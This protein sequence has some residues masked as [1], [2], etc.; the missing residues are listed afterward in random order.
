[1]KHFLSRLLLLPILF[2]GC[3]KYDA[4]NN[5]LIDPPGARIKTTIV[6]VVTDEAGFLLQGATIKLEGKITANSR[7]DGVFIL[8]NV[9]V[10]AARFYLKASLNNY[11]ESGSGG[12]PVKGGVT[13]VQIK[14]VSMGNPEIVSSTDASTID[15]NGAKLSFPA[16]A[17]VSE[18]G[19][20]H[21]GLVKVYA[22]SLNPSIAN[23]SDLVPGGDLYSMMP[24]SSASTL[25]SYGMVGVEL[26]DENNNEL[27]LA[28]GK[29][30]EI[31][32]PIASSQ[33]STAPNEI[34]LLW[35]DPSTGIWKLEGEAK[36]VGNEYVGKVKHFSWWNCDI[37]RFNCR[38]RGR[39]VDCD[40]KPLA[41]VTVVVNHQYSRITDANGY[42]DGMVPRI[43]LTFEVK[44]F[45][46][47]EN[48][49]SALI[50]SSP[51]DGL[52]LLPDIKVGNCPAYVKGSISFCGNNKDFYVIALWGQ[53]MKEGWVPTMVEGSS[54][55]LSV[56]VGKPVT[57]RISSGNFTKDTLIAALLN[58]QTL[59]L[60]QIAGC[61][62]VP[63]VKTASI[64][65]ASETSA[66]SGGE[67]V[68]N[69]GDII[70]ARGVVW[71]T[72]PNP[73]VNLNTKTSDGTGLGVYT[74][75]IAGL[76]KNTKYYLRAY[77][78]NS[79]GTGY[80]NE[81]LFIAEKLDTNIFNSSISYGSIADID[82]NVYKTVQIGTQTWMAE[83]LRVT[84]YRNG[85][86]IQQVSDSVQWNNIFKSS[87]SSKQAAWCYYQ[88]NV[89]NNI[90][91]GKLYNWYAVSNSNR[92]CPTG[93]HI[94][95][96]N[97]WIILENELEGS[98]EAGG[99]M[100]SRGTQYW[101]SPNS[102]A[103][104]SSGFSGLPGGNR[105]ETGSF[106]SIKSFGFWWS[107]SDVDAKAARYYFLSKEIPSLFKAYYGLKENGYSVRCVKD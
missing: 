30:A 63:S 94:P 55:T 2:L 29:E 68:S 27:K 35:L 44:M 12:I 77:A 4:A 96:E 36:K 62:T 107:S 88:N 38:I 95:N 8:Q 31:R 15:F 41:G 64:S 16:N 5:S 90:P 79:A 26:I 14:L 6:G 45:G 21:S 48:L 106:K 78:T 28:D 7:K 17:F 10:P 93:W 76:T 99:K 101:A 100:K 87:T 47:T 20:P 3:R 75:S 34:P 11:F 23:F 70:T 52:N 92:I 58:G 98:A 19:T 13:Y 1:M 66:K 72:S 56:P 18:N 83:N 24:D 59:N 46:N 54:F 37:Q 22:R 43:P 73:T 33:L 51:Q 9:E 42:Y 50:L 74:S 53:S 65:N 71:S 97:E 102:G 40:G 103:S 61:I 81:I 67:V 104:N 84:K 105:E 49:S 86:S 57:I 89:N 80:G 39:V 91:Y 85:T 25:E 69:G 32:F 60:G 82:G